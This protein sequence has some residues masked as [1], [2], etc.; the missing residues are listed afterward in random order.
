MKAWFIRMILFWMYYDIALTKSC[1]QNAKETLAHDER[2]IQQLEM[3][4]WELNHD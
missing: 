4:L 2:R 1:I 3:E